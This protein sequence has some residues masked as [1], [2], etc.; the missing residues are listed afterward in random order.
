M[1]IVPEHSLNIHWE[2]CQYWRQKN[3]LLSTQ[4]KPGLT[5]KSTNAKTEGYLAE[6]RR[7]GFTQSMFVL[8]PN[9]GKNNSS[10]FLLPLI[11]KKCLFHKKLNTSCVYTKMF[12]YCICTHIYVHV[13]ITKIFSIF[14]CYMYSF[15]SKTIAFTSTRQ[16]PSQKGARDPRSD[17]PKGRQ[18]MVLHVRRS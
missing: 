2:Q 9:H 6:L 11:Y 16:P 4:R 10:L 18:Q 3:I 14:L 12:I 8:T 17:I 13:Y 1:N 15:L 7:A 5:T